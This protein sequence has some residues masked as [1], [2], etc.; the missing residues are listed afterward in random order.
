MDE[1][2]YK[3]IAIIRLTALGD[4]IHALP[5]FTLLREAF[6]QSK[7]SWFVEPAGAKLL[8]NFTGIDDVIV[9]NLKRN[10]FLSK[11]KEVKRLRSFYGKKGTFDLVLDFQGLL[12]SA[13]LAR[14]LRGRVSVGFHKEN[15]KESLSRFFYKRTV[16][17]F[18]E[19][20]HVA[21]KNIHLADFEGHLSAR[22][23]RPDNEGKIDW[24]KINI[25][26]R[27]LSQ[28][29][30]E[31]D[32]FLSTHRLEKNNFVILN[33]GGGWETKLLSAGQYIE[34]VNGI[35]EKYPV[36]V[37]WGNEKEK[38]TAEEICRETGVVLADF[39]D[40][41][42]LIL[43]IRCSRLIVTGDTLALHLADLVKTPSVGIF[44]P[45]SPSRNG[46]LMED[47]IAVYKKLPCGFC[48]KKKCGTIECIKKLN[49]KNIIETIETLY[50]K[51]Y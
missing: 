42:Q 40:F 24:N 37:L 6:P 34:V 11:L 1:T 41:S 32:Q 9:V 7:I 15:L 16:D 18:D 20:N 26:L 29:R 12:K 45:T 2:K 14:L 48:Y 8:E 47:S 50:E 33:V 25:P 31:M 51:L 35:R 28:R 17:V 22:G 30:E 3:S 23:L 39:F 13:L 36:V 44:G 21:L 5:A 10:G 49:S 19:T 43:F 46:S 27:D 4:I 38:G